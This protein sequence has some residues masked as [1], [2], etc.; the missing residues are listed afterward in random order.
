[1]DNLRVVVKIKGEN[2]H[3]AWGTEIGTG[4]AVELWP[5][6]AWVILSPDSVCLGLFT[7]A[8]QPQTKQGVF[9]IC[10]LAFIPASVS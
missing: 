9:C 8:Q 1:M 3:E 5:R 10:G 2:E 6:G 4:M 7:G